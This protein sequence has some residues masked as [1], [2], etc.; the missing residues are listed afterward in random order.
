MDER[1]HRRQA[2]YH[3]RELGIDPDDVAELY[4]Q[5][6]AGRPARPKKGNDEDF[7]EG[8]EWHLRGWMR[9]TG[10]KKRGPAL[11]LIAG[12]IYQALREDQK[13]AAVSAKALAD[14][15]EIKLRK[16]GFHNRKLDT[17]RPHGVLL[18]FLRSLY[19]QR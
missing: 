14:R 13:K 16:G 1:D 2:R 9:Q 4:P 17:L 8:L 11:L 12:G 3:L 6:A 19:R 15:W 7:L 10:Q 18:P 5:L